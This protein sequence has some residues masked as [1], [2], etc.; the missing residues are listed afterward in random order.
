[1]HRGGVVPARI[2]SILA[3]PLALASFG[4]GGDGDSENADSVR[5]LLIDTVPE[6]DLGV[7]AGDTSELFNQVVGAT[8]LD[9][10]TVIV[11]DKGSSQLK[12]FTRDGRH[13]RSV[14]R[15]GTGPGE[16]GSM[17]DL[18]R[19]GDSLFVKDIASRGHVV[20]GVDGGYARLL[21]FELPEAA[22]APYRSVCNA[23]RM[24]FHYAY[25]N[26]RVD[27]KI[28]VYR[29]NVPFW[30]TDPDGAVVHQLGRHPGS[31]RLGSPGGSRPLPLGK[32]TATA[33]GTDRT[34][35]GTADG[36]QIVVTD[37][38]G[39]RLD[40]IQRSDVD[41]RTTPADIELYK[42]RDLA[43]TN[44]GLRDA[45]ER[46]YA[47]IPFPEYIPAYADVLVD[48]SANLWVQDYPRGTAAYTR[49][50]IFS[51][52]G[53]LVAEAQLPTRLEVYEI[54]D[55]YVLGKTLEPP[56]DVEHV[57]VYRLPRRPGT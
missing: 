57:R 15:E 17:A 20:F 27:G 42:Q 21:R 13:T 1:V 8:R 48:A 10:G 44:P 28:G 5:R 2:R 56:D 33:L 47:T 55:D 3:V 32:Q 45:I 29:A 14:G 31:E 11:A 54:G 49:W 12:Y 30:I 7:V 36:Y 4:C 23:N 6:L 9:D 38:S 53:E 41:L 26:I 52:A 19:C 22:R 39:N 24:F 37:F 43:A 34:Y 35:I 50:S 25:E 51:P 40:T 16:F 46:S 18:L